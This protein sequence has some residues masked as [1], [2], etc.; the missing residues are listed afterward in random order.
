M[1]SFVVIGLG[2]FGSSVARQL[3]ELGAE[4]RKKRR[5]GA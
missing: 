3:C 1:N 4:V 2:L 5:E